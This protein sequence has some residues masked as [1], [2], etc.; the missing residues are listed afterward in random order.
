MAQPA[1]RPPAPILPLVEHVET[2][3]DLAKKDA[4]DVWEQLCKLFHEEYN[5]WRE[6]R[7][8][9]W[10]REDQENLEAYGQFY[11]E[12]CKSQTEEARLE[13]VRAKQKQLKRK[14]QDSFKWWWTEELQKVKE[15]RRVRR[16][17]EGSNGSQRAPI[18]IRVRTGTHGHLRP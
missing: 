16:R 5:E 12:F 6:A 1:A 11:E 9:E 4:S 7:D 17:G 8:K 14:V 13:Q 2:D 15:G 18:E 10:N 3:L